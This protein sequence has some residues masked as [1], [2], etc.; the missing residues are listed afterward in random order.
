MA[1][2]GRIDYSQ[3][4]ADGQ[5]YSEKRDFFVVTFNQEMS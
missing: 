2:E 5:G 3:C 4:A 1:A